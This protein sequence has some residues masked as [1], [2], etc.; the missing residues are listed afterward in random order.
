MNLYNLDDVLFEND[1]EFSKEKA[2]WK[3]I[4][5][6][7]RSYQ[8]EAING[9]YNPPMTITVNKEQVHNGF[10]DLQTNEGTK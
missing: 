1:D 3:V 8:L 7:R 6:G 10:L 9:D 2:L 4:N 5:I